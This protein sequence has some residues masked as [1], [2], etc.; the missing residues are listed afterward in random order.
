LFGDEPTEL[1]VTPSGAPPVLRDQEAGRR[2]R[3][4]PWIVAL[5]VVLAAAG[6]G[7]AWALTRPSPLP[8]HQLLDVRGKTESEARSA[9]GALKLRARVTSRPLVDNTNSGAVIS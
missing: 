2:R 4:W 3:R 6:A 9:L 8:T 7:A 1:G 5:V